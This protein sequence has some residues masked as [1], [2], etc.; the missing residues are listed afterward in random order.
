MKLTKIISALFATVVLIIFT[1]IAC[2]ALSIAPTIPMV[3]TAVSCLIPTPAG[4]ACVGIFIAPGGAA[5]SFT[6][7]LNYLPEHLSFSN[8]VP[9]TSLKVETDTDGVLHDWTSP[10]LV[11]MSNFMVKGVVPANIVK[12]RLG[13]GEIRPKNVTISGITSA[14]GAVPV[15]I[16]SDR[17]GKI[18]LKS[19]NAICFPKTPTTFTQFTAL[20]IPT[21]A[22]LTDF[23]II[24]YANGLTQTLTIEDLKNESAEYQQTPGIIIN[25]HKG[26]I[27]QVIL[28][29]LVQTPVYVL[30]AVIPGQIK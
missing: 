20:F 4:M 25:N 19:K 27:S 28:T 24:T 7:P 18:L 15:F 23:A 5:V 2:M 17:V 21:M 11:A 14:A 26:T 6:F 16:S 22:T 30:E 9:L 8:V 12:F 3:I 1:D 10:G 13:D 29:C